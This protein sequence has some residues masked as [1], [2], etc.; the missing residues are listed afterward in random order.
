MVELIKECPKCGKEFKI[1]KRRSHKERQFCSQVCANTRLHRE[2]TK[3]KISNSLA[4]DGISRKKVS[5][6][7]KEC[8]KKIYYRNKSGYCREHISQHRNLTEETYAA[9]SQAGKH[10]CLAQKES[11]RSKN[12]KLFCEMCETYFKDVKHNEPIF[13]GWDADVIIE[14]IKT[15]V[16][17]NGKWHYKSIAGHA[18]GQVQNRDKI[19]LKEIEKCGYRTYIIQDMGKENSIF[20]QKEFDKFIAG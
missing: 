18:L 15:A 10:S 14:D 19:K 2:I 12:E 8:G 3:E 4:R 1:I 5:R 9:L 17:W 20:V 16:L 11:R 7:C 6:Y 13:N